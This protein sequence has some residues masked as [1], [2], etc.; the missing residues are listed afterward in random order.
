MADY[1]RLPKQ[2]SITIEDAIRAG[3]R[4]ISYPSRAILITATVLGIA[5]PLCGLSIWLFPACVVVGII[6]A[7]LHTIWMTPQ[8]RI[9]AYAGVRDIH[10]FQRCAELELLLPKQSPMLMT[11]IMTSEQRATLA[12]LQ[13]RFEEDTP[14]IDDPDV[15]QVS[16]IYGALLSFADRDKPQITISSEGIETAQHGFYAWKD[17]RNE[18]VGTKSF[19][20]RYSYRRMGRGSSS[21]ADYF[22]FICPDL[23]VEIPVASLDA[24]LG[25]LDHMLYIHRG[26]Y[27]QILA[28]HTPTIPLKG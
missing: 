11:G 26:R 2:G 9:W 24:T 4:S 10:Q 17:I 27:E 5:L 7:F 18:H 1:K 15:D 28:G 6:A 19:V 25:E 13:H 21:T 16:R 22:C 23:Q 12:R 20:S 14:F 8:W 3:K